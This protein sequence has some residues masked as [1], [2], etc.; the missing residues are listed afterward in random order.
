MPG[1]LSHIAC[2][3]YVKDE[4]LKKEILTED[5]VVDFYSG[6]LIPDL[7]I[8]KD[9]T[10]HEVM[11][12]IDGVFS[13]DMSVV[14]EKYFNT[15]NAVLLGVYCHLLL[16]SIFI[17]NGLLKWFEFN[18]ECRYIQKGNRR[19]SYSQFFGRH[20]IYGDYTR[21]NYMMINDGWVSFEIINSIPDLLPQTG[22]KE[23]DERRAETWRQELEGYLR[24][25][26][27]YSYGIIEYNN[28]LNIV[29]YAANVFLKGFQ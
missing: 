24:N 12:N 16:D 10:H 11:T 26:D 21:M 1:M 8:H 4:L 20:G 22:F 29:T 2:A 25:K 9:A 5:K 15:N 28:L 6:N 17:N 18:S 7:A 13:P 14:K 19:Y 27:V 3:K 23:M